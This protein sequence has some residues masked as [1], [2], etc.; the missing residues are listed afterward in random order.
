MKKIYLYVRACELRLLD[1]TRIHDYL[2]L[3]GYKIVYTPEDADIIVFFTCAFSNF[4][5]NCALEKIKDFQKNYNAEL[6][7]GGCL[8]DISPGKL[9]EFFD[10]KIISTK[11]IQENEDILDIILPGNKIKFKDQKD[12]NV[13]YSF[14]YGSNFYDNIK[15]TE[16]IKK[17]SGLFRKTIYEKK[18]NKIKDHIDKNL[19]ALPALLNRFLKNKSFYAVRISWGCP[20]NCSYCA[21]KKA[22]GKLKSK[23]I[24]QCISEFKNGL[25]LG[26][27][28]FIINADNTGAYGLDI[29]SNFAE[30][31]DEITKISGDFE[32]T[33]LD[34]DPMWIVK[35]IDIFEE[36]LKRRKIISME[37]T[38]QSGSSRILKLMNRYS[39]IEKIK[40][41]LVRLKK[42]YPD[43]KLVIHQIIG[44][45][46]ETMDDLDK[47]LSFITEMNID[48][49]YSFSFSRR[50]GTDSEKIKP[51]LSNKEIIKRLSYTKKYLKKV[52]YD[53]MDVSHISS[54]VYKK[55]KNNKS[56]KL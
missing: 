43:L 27:K 31:L 30:L 26:Y 25:N 21:I 49:G 44:F 3:N 33:I 23:S 32:I 10:G 34:L 37:I 24:D 7:I 38:V 42:S 40:N 45:P 11:K 54:L 41:G 53:V 16:S 50:A 19:F 28:T 35:Y 12:A 17:L 18:F 8:P 2:S 15:R 51:K 1:A 47:T 39:D 6:I 55:R 52:G 29:G 22:V 36:I 5:E 14:L 13:P 20:S 9:S 4:Q 56:D 46:T 48:E